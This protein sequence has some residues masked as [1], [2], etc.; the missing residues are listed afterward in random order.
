[1]KFVSLCHLRAQLHSAAV[2]YV[3]IISQYKWYHAV[4][5][6]HNYTGDD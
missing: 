2:A 1:M 6:N 4:G 5:V 3:G